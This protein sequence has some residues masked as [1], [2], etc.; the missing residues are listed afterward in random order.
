MYGGYNELGGFK[1]S[2]EKFGQDLVSWAGGWAQ[3]AAGPQ[4]PAPKPT[5][6]LTQPAPVKVAP[7]PAV[8]PLGGIPPMVL[9]AGAGVLA[10]VLFS[11]K[12]R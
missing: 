8:S 3:K 10:F 9:L 12:R 1:D 5:T 6:A 4:Q 11:R 7:A 2:I